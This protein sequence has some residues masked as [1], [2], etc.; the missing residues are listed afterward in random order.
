LLHPNNRSQFRRLVD[1]LYAKV[2]QASELLGTKIIESTRCSGCP[3]DTIE[4][5]AAQLAAPDH[6]IVQSQKYKLEDRI[7]QLLKHAKTNLEHID[8]HYPLV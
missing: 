8:A 7:Y 4:Y 5:P 2:S 3:E 6:I 1:D